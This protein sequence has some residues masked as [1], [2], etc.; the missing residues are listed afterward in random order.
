[1]FARFVTQP[2]AVRS[3]RGRRLRFRFRTLAASA[4]M[5]ACLGGCTPATVPL[6]GADPA[7]PSAKVAPIGY[8]S[9]IA[10]YTP[11]RPST[12]TGWGGAGTAPS[13]PDR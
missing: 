5:A 7:E 13:R 10:P 9:T 1:M 12:P 6:A 8:G 3:A 2:A 4:A 11:M